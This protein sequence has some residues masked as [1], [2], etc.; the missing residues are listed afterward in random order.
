[1]PGETGD[2]RDDD[3]H[4]AHARRRNARITRSLDAPVPVLESHDV[5]ELGGRH[6]E[7]V[8]VDERA[9]AVARPG[10]DVPAVARTEPHGRA[11]VVFATDLE[12][13]R[14]R[15]NAH[16]LVLALVILEAQRLARTDVQDLAHVAVGARPDRLVTP[17][18][19]HVLGDNLHSP[20]SHTWRLKNSASHTW[21]LIDPALPEPRGRHV[22]GCRTCAR[23]SRGRRRS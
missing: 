7:D 2:T 12:L 3:A 22:G 11:R 13:E 15:E 1:P 4:R 6:L 9:H 17:G 18:L 19:R 5:V 21:R 23:S 16:R 8:R 14:A 20:A 10:R